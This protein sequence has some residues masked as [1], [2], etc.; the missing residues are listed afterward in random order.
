[1]YTP[2]MQVIAPRK[3]HPVIVV[4]SGASGGMAA[5][6]LTRKGVKV[7]MLDAG[8]R[9]KKTDFW[10]HTFPYEYRERIRK[11]ERP[12][13]FFLSTKEQPYQTPADQPFD[14]VRVW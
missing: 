7:L 4:G 10:I 2:P 8:Q 12:P 14:L 11:G 5:W 3:V 9:F 1:M 13:S 6:N